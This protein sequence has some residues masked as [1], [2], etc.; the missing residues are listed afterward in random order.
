MNYF[1]D[2]TL[3]KYRKLLFINYLFLLALTVTTTALAQSDKDLWIFVQNDR[4]DRVQQLLDTGLDPN[5]RTGIGNPIIMQAVRDGAWSVFDMVLKHPDT[6]INILNGYQET[7]LMYVSLVGDL[8]RVKALIARGA[9]INQL[10]WTPLH[11]AAAKGQLPVVEYLLEKGAMPNAPA[12]S[13]ESP[14]M[15]AARA[16]AID[17]VQR[18]LK[19]GADPA[20]VDM[21]GNNAVTAAR[22]QGH[23]NLA[24]ALQKVIRDRSATPPTK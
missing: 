19:A 21:N 14:I 9:E 1:N 22:D 6:E 15:M 13:G 2:S 17:T 8:D 11:Y 20:A 24:Q 18:L 16:G 5:T 4:A 3:N 12:P 7:P 10:G 23:S